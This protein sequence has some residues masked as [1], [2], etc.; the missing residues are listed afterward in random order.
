LDYLAAIAKWI[1]VIAFSLAASKKTFSL[2]VGTYRWHPIFV[3]HSRIRS[4]AGQL[5]VASTVGD[6]LVVGTLLWETRLGAVAAGLA[7]V[8]YTIAG[9][10]PARSSGGC[11]CLWGPLD[12]STSAG[13]VARNTVL[14]FCAVSVLSFDPAR[15][16][17]AD[18]FL[19]G[20]GLVAIGLAVRGLERL[21]GEGEPQH[22]DKAVSPQVPGV[23]GRPNNG[24]G[25]L[26][27]E[28]PQ[29]RE[30]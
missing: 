1:L 30:V 14:L 24:R 6:L 16:P 9:Y 4:H 29:S 15:T 18:V 2:K 19:G 28:L 10:G 8:L 22:V 17:V 26:A 27:R 11:Q 21:S 20:L 13:L 25:S 12:S 23:L 3:G 7:L 5:T